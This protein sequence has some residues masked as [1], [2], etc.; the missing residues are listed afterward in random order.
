MDPEV[1][2]HYQ[3]TTEFDSDPA[4]HKTQEPGEAQHT[5]KQTDNQ[6]IPNE[7]VREYDHREPLY[8]R[9]GFVHHHA[10][11]V[12]VLLTLYVKNDFLDSLNLYV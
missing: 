11:Q 1:Q 10:E 4:Q 7:R 5:S 8:Q 9:H 3:Q 12:Q 6:N 2:Q